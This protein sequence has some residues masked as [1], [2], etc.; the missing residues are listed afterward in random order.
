MTETQLYL[1]VGLPTIAVLVGVLINAM[2]FNA[3]FATLSARM[4]S[5]ENRMTALESKFDSR[6]D[7]IISKLVDLDNRLTR[8]E[9]WGW[10]RIYGRALGYEDLNDREQLRQ[11]P[12]MRVLA[13]KAESALRRRCTA[14]GRDLC[15][16]CGNPLG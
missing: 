7:M 11:D 1:A 2:Q 6:F 4:S 15:E 5:I 8:V 16:K 10:Q 12:L 13:G 3:Q 14:A 9:Q